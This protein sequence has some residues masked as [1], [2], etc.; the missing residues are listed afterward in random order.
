MTHLQPGWSLC[1]WRRRRG[2]GGW[3]DRPGPALTGSVQNLLESHWSRPGGLLRLLGLLGPGPR[4]GQ[5]VPA[6]LSAAAPGS[7]PRLLLAAPQHLAGGE[8]LVP[9]VLPTLRHQLG[10]RALPVRPVAGAGV[11]DGAEGTAVLPGEAADTEVVLAAVLRVGVLS[12][13]PWLAVRTLELPAHLVQHHGAAAL[14]HLIRPAAA[15]ALLVVGQAGRA[16]V[17]GGLAGLADPEDSAVLGVL[18]GSPGPGTVRARDGRL[19]LR[20]LPALHQ[21]ELGALLQGEGLVGVDEAEAVAAGSLLGLSL[22]A[23]P[24]P[25]TAVEVRVEAGQSVGAGEVVNPLARH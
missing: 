14:G 21:V 24:V 12:E 3:S 11:E 16:G 13:D 17:A 19:Q 1:C 5:A 20:P 9:V 7:L 23:G 22:R 2:R 15:V 10:V 8:L 25:V 6:E 18:V 4:S